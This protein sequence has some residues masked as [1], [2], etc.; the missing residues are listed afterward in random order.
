MRYYPIDT[1]TFNNQDGQTVQVKDKREIP[2]YET[3]IQLKVE[4]GMMI[5]EVISRL[6]LYGEDNEDLSYAVLDHNIIKLTENNFDISKL[7][8]LKIPEIE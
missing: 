5:D 7:D 3:L 6:Q 1:L 2:S 8:Y 4:K